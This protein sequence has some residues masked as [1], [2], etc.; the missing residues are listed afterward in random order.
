MTVASNFRPERAFDV[1]TS[2]I[3]RDLYV[4]RGTDAFLFG[5]VEARIWN[6]CDASNSI[7]DIATHV[8]DVFRVEESLAVDDVSEF[9]GQLM[10]A[11]LVE[12]A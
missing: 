8:A 6:L 1:Q 12:E 9:V 3:D 5:E 10:E 2:T 11:G 4:V 7:A